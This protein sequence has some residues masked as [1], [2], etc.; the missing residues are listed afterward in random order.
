MNL[1]FNDISISCFYHTISMW[2][3]HMP[4]PVRRRDMIFETH[5]SDVRKE[6][7]Q[8]KNGKKK[9]RGLELFSW[10]LAKMVLILA[11]QKGIRK[12]FW[13]SML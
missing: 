6:N 1:I 12:H 5:S 8:Q 10:K 2:S 3:K 4:H 9:G 11:T 7:G 13:P